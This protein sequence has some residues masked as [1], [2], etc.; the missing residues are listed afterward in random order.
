MIYLQ[1]E[2]ISS[3]ET[4]TRV[5]RKEWRLMSAIALLFSSQTEKLN[6]NALTD[7]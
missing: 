1:L 2:S 6:R 5:E 3:N 7:G 4:W